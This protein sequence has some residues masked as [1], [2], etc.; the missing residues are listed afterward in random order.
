MALVAAFRRTRLAGPINRTSRRGRNVELA[1]LGVAVGSTYASTS[2]RKLFASAE[3]RAALDDEA[4]AAHAPSRSP[5]GS[6]T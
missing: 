2:A 5:S 6:A 3:R 1:R 4:R